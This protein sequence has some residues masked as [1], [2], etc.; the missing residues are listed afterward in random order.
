MLGALAPTSA[1]AGPAEGASSEGVE[2][3]SEDGPSEPAVDATTDVATDETSTTEPETD[4]VEAEPESAD[5]LEADGNPDDELEEVDV[6]D[7]SAPTDAEPIRPP[8][9]DGP[10]FGV[11]AMGTLS[12][13]HVIDLDTPSPLGGGGGFIQAG[14]AVFPWMSIG[15]ALGGHTGV[16]GS[17]MLAQGSLL[18]EFGFIPVQRYPLSIRAGFGFGGGRVIDRAEGVRPGFGGALFKGSIRYEFFPLAAK[19]RPDRG[20]GWAIGPELGWLG[21]TPA[22]KGQPFVNTILLGVS[23]SFYFGS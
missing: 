15:I 13:A 21:A 20:G 4:E 10:Y 7:G 11:L 9:V 16:A 18:V 12:F 1:W 2:Q 22:G 5:E 17:Q 23:T 3:P 14:D 6:D 19:R 8:R